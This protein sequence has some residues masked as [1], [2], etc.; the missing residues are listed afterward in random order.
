MQVQVQI[1]ATLLNLS[2]TLGYTPP[3][4][5]RMADPQ[6]FIPILGPQ[7]WAFNSLNG[8]LSYSIL[9]NDTIQGWPQFL[10]FVI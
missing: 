8:S 10:A 2:Y 5:A 4:A 3:P 1:N 6:K 9:N 7:P